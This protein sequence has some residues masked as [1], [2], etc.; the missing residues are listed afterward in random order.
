MILSLPKRQPFWR[1][2]PNV[3]DTGGVGSRG[4][5]RNAFRNAERRKHAQECRALLISLRNTFARS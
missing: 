1:E 4:C 5:R 2:S 3:G